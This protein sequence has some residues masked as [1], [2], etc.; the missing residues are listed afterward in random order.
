MPRA[1]DSAMT[2]VVAIDGFVS[3]A[4][5]IIVAVRMSL[6]EEPTAAVAAAVASAVAAIEAVVTDLVLM[7]VVAFGVAEDFGTDFV[8][9]NAERTVLAGFL[10][11]GYYY[12]IPVAAETAFLAQTMSFETSLYSPL[13]LCSGV[14]F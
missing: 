10:I 4:T 12:A 13:N 5:R 1:V 2:E 14:S 8:V 11:T 7:I 6:L 3:A 9:T